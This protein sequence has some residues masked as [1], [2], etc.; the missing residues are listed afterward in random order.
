MSK[1]SLLTTD[2][3]WQL[4]GLAGQ[5]NWTSSQKRPDMSFGACEVSTLIKDAQ[6]GDVLNANKDIKKL[7]SQ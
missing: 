3:A 6:I 5:F 7:K 2:G 4:R 1:D